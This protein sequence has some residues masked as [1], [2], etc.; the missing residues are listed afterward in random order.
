LPK[1]V[2][3][4]AAP[5]GSGLCGPAHIRPWAT[6]RERR[7]SISKCTADSNDWS[8]RCI[9]LMSRW[10]REIESCRR[11]RGRICWSPGLFQATSKPVAGPSGS[12]SSW[13]V[14]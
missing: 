13:L 8:R 11:R 3:T 6:G 9:F 5:F 1:S 10:T 14:A 7:T 2:P 12:T 4:K